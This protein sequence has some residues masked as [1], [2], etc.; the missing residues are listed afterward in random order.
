LTAINLAKIENWFSRPKE[1]RGAFSM[2][3]VKTLQHNTLL[4]ERFIDVFAIN[5]NKVKNKKHIRRLL[6][7][8]E[9]AA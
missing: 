4:L 9:I 5:P 2:A 1:T 3:N 7:Y 8:G 6:I